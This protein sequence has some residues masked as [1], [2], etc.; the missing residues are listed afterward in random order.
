MTKATTAHDRVE[1]EPKLGAKS[2][3]GKARLLAAA[4]ALGAISHTLGV[5]LY[6]R[7]LYPKRF[8]NRET[9]DVIRETDAGINVG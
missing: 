5:M 7:V 6:C 8:P 2:V 4:G 1:A 9:L 3:F